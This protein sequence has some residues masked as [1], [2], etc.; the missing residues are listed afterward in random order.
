MD[1]A[2]DWVWVPELGRWGLEFHSVSYV[3]AEYVTV[4]LSPN[5]GPDTHKTLSLWIYQPSAVSSAIFGGVHFNYQ[6]LYGYG[7]NCRNDGTLR[8]VASAGTTDVYDN[9]Y[10]TL[11]SGQ[12]SHAAMTATGKGAGNTLTLFINGHEIAS[13]TGTITDYNYACLIHSHITTSQ[14]VGPISDPLIYNRALTLPEIQALAD[15]SNAMLS[16][17]LLPPRRV[18]WPVSGGATAESAWGSIFSTSIISAS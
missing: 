2:T 7:F 13:Y 4:P 3:R 5:P 11:P 1:P 10:G 18:W 17:L 6:S 15:P 12:W 8:C 9:V 16:G 14:F